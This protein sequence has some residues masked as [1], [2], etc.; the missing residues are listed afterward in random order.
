MKT[1]ILFLL[2]QAAT[3]KAQVPIN[4]VLNTA[5]PQNAQ[6]NVGTGTVRGTLTVGTLLVTNLSVGNL[7]VT[8]ISGSGAGLTN[9]PAAQLTGTV[10]SARIAGAYTGITQIGTITAGTWHGDVLGTQ[11][12][13]TG[14]NFV[15][16]STGD[17]VYFSGTGVMAALTPGSPQQLLQSNGFAAPSW[18][19]T[20]TINGININNIQPLYIA[21]GTIPSFVKVDD[22]SILS[23]SAAKVLGNISG[24]SAGISGSL[25]LFKLSSGTLNANIVASSITPTGIVPGVYGSSNTSAQFIVGSDGRLRYAASLPIPGVGP[26]TARTDVDNGFTA[27]QTIRNSSATIGTDLLVIDTVTAAYYKGD[28]GGI[29]NINAA[30]VNGILS[31]TGTANQFTYFT[32]T[33]VV[34]S[35]GGFTINGTTMRIGNVNSPTPTSDVHLVL[36]NGPRAYNIN[37]SEDPVYIEIAGLGGS[38]EYM[39][40]GRNGVQFEHIG[41]D[42]SGNNFAMFDDEPSFGSRPFFKHENASDHT[43]IGN[44]GNTYSAIDTPTTLSVYGVTTAFG[45]SA[46]QNKSSNNNGTMYYNSNGQHYQ[47]SEDNKAYVILP[48]LLATG[49]QGAIPYFATS[50]TSYLTSD[51]DFT[52]TSVLGAIAAVASSTGALDVRLTAAEA[53]VAALRVS[54]ASLQAQMD[55]HTAQITQL[56][57]QDSNIALSTAAIAFSTGTLQ[58]QILTL[59]VST[60]NLQA[61]VAALSASTASLQTQISAIVVSS[62]ALA[63]QV[64]ALNAST[65]ALQVGLNNVALSTAAIASSTGT[66]QAQVFG[67]FVSTG[68]LQASI[69]TLSASTVSLQ[70]QINGI[71]VSTTNVQG[72]ITALGASTAALHIIDLAVGTST[73]SL[74]SQITALGASTAAIQIE[75]NNVA[76]A[77]GTI[78]TSTG[79]LQAQIYLVGTATAA[80]QTQI[81]ALGAST[82]TESTARIAGFNAVG[83]STNSLQIQITAIG[84]STAANQTQITALGASTA[85]ESAARIAGFT[86]VGSSTNSLQIQITALGASTAA[87]QVEINNVATATGTIAASTSS[88]QGQINNIA[89]STAAIA[90]S[91]GTLQASIAALAISTAGLQVQITALGASTNTLNNVKASTGTNSDIT[92]LLSLQQIDNLLYI[93]GSR[94]AIGTS[95]VSTADLRVIQQTNFAGISL[96]HFSTDQ[97]GPAFIGRKAEGTINAPATVTAGDRLATFGGTGFDGSQFTSSTSANIQFFSTETWTTSAHG[98]YATLSTIPSG[99]TTPVVSATFGPGAFI[100][101]N[102]SGLTGIHNSSFTNIPNQTLTNTAFAGC[103]TASSVTI[104]SLAGSYLRISLSG[105]AT[106]TNNNTTISFGLLIDGSTPSQYG[107]SPAIRIGVTPA[108]SPSLVALDTVIDTALSAGSHTVCLR[109]FTSANTA[110]ITNDATTVTRFGITEER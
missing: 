86:A 108:A 42:P 84:A 16:V 107:S 99:S 20:P 15:S 3:V 24:N 54:T 27:P 67:L 105:S 77:T 91:T 7:T 40:F 55:V 21:T 9:L 96:D 37:L 92:A 57:N 52:T 5:T 79:N 10:A 100:G 83:S 1:I 18:T 62:A 80:N 101:G 59:F 41:V 82:A 81:T 95:V 22:P 56:K 109:A 65:A 93:T 43:T 19:G 97:V 70:T 63:A 58:A 45:T 73:G 17:I 89:L 26:N 13:G 2:L 66:L 90:T 64:A 29:T 103:L 30:N 71:V 34:A 31:G 110:T 11:Y 33:K 74:Q 68:N 51:V 78:A 6:F 28:G 23:V 38:S 32:N 50:G 25:P 76:V 88:L 35:T 8:S 36:G 69:A 98:T 44:G 49:T 94:I 47:F 102:G 48:G 53:G 46:I 61:S 60:G 106:N 14:Q 39:G 72:Q 85:T 75:I 4:A 104:T 12:G 87:I